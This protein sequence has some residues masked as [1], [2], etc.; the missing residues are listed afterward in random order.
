MRCK[1]QHKEYGQWHCNK[2]LYG[3]RW[4]LDSSRW[5]LHNV[6]TRQ[7]ISTPGTNTI[8]YTNYISILK[9]RKH[10]VIERTP[11]PPFQ[12]I[13]QTPAVL[14]LETQDPADISVPASLPPPAMVHPVSLSGFRGAHRSVPHQELQ[15][16]EK[17]A[18]HR[19]MLFLKLSDCCWDF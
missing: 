7:I 12:P 19:Q 10:F 9:K 14:C 16:K 17:K 5:P 4:L 15:T 3:D 18:S 2:T 11:H 1:M 8:L 6:R 13:A